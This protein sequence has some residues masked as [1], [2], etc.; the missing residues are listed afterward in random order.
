M[1]IISDRT[2]SEN[3]LGN[4]LESGWNLV[5]IGNICHRS[6]TKLMV[7]FHVESGWNL[8]GKVMASLELLGTTWYMWGSAKYCPKLP[9]GYPC[10]CLIATEACGLQCLC[11]NVNP[12]IADDHRG[13]SK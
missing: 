3:P 7:K 5:R 8:V 1:M 2:Y 12:A 6:V 10:H 9:A 13:P 4:W 11:Q